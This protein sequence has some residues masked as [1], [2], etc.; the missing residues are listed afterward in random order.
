MESFE[1]RAEK[2]GLKKTN[3]RTFLYEDRYGAVQYVGSYIENGEDFV[4]IPYYTVYGAPTS[5]KFGRLGGFVSEEYQ[6][7]GNEAVVE[8]IK[9]SIV[10]TGKPILRE[11]TIIDPPKYT[12][13]LHELEIDNVVTIPQEGDVIP[14]LTVQ[15][16]YDGTGVARVSFG[17]SLRG[18]YRLTF[19]KKMGSYY[20][21]HNASSKTVLTGVIGSF[22]EIFNENIG[23]LISANSSKILSDEDILKALAYIEERAGKRR[24]AD[25]STFLAELCKGSQTTNWNLFLAIAKFSSKEGTLNSKVLLDNIAERL[26]V[27]PEKMIRA[28]GG[29]K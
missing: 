16:T 11:W 15:N 4:P 25:I 18:E 10:G 14:Q 19:N 5:Q 6:F 20:Q 26:L 13:F 12:R 23:E 21:I 17:I 28:L 24:R 2:G 3:K 1:K 22:F 29:K 7:I 27:V 8:K 9:E